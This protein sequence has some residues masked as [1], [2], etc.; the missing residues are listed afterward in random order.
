MITRQKF[1]RLGC[2]SLDH[3]S[4]SPGLLPT[5][6]HFFKH[7]GNFLQEKCLRN[8]RDAETASN[9]FAASGTAK[10]HDIGIRKFLFSDGKSALKLMVFI[11]INKYCSTK[12]SEQTSDT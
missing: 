3:L 5:D 6:Y 2:E 10:F 4:Y 1:N 12:R 8:P 9:G 7:L 11:F